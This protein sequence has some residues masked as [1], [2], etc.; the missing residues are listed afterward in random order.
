MVYR[1]MGGAGKEHGAVRGVYMQVLEYDN[2]CPGGV[3]GQRL[4]VGRRLHGAGAG[5]VVLQPGTD[6]GCAKRLPFI[7]DRNECG[8][9]ERGNA[10]PFF[11]LQSRVNTGKGGGDF[12]AGLGR[13]G[14]GRGMGGAGRSGEKAQGDGGFGKDR[15]TLF[16]TFRRE[17]KRAGG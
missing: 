4:N 5:E 13:H 7:V 2:D 10:E 16:Y 3:W 14:G 12:G 11:A 17:L 8:G 6:I 9:A 15:H 1:G